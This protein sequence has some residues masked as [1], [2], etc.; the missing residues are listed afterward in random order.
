MANWQLSSPL[1][2]FYTKRGTSP[3]P[4]CPPGTEARP[5]VQTWLRV[6]RSRAYEEAI[7]VC[8]KS[9]L[10]LDRSSWRNKTKFGK[11]EGEGHDERA[12]PPPL[13]SLFPSN[14]NSAG[15]EKQEISI[16]I[17]ISQPAPY[18]ARYMCQKEQKKR[19]SS[20]SIG[21]SLDSIRASFKRRFTALLPSRASVS[22]QL[23]PDGS[24]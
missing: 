3:T 1:A 9:K 12:V 6:G 19:L 13:A 18:R 11:S 20:S 15:H 5:R 21:F 2:V 10:Q 14:I 8:Q 23:R 17:I 24:E 16:H 22:W 4:W 7:R